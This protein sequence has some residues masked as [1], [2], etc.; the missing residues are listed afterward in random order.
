MTDFFAAADGPLREH[1]VEALLT[2]KPW[3]VKDVDRY[4]NTLL[5]HLIESFMSEELVERV[6]R[7]N[8]EAVCVR[9]RNSESPFHLA[10]RTYNY[11]AMNL[12][13]SQLSF[14]DIVEA[15]IDCGLPND[16]SGIC[17]VIIKQCEDMAT[18]LNR[19]VMQTIYLYLGLEREKPKVEKL[20]WR[21]K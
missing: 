18:L 12:W 21:A 8:T 6:W 15:F 3:R 2:S 11:W 14:D 13:Q 19:D 9:N 10:I 1:D 16:L 5:H 20:N 17:P 7:M 4:G